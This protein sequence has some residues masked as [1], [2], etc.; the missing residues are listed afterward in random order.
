MKFILFLFMFSFFLGLP[1]WAGQWSFATSQSNTVKTHFKHSIP[2]YSNKTVN[3]K[4]KT[5]SS[6]PTITPSA[7]PSPTPVTDALSNV[8]VVRMTYTPTLPNDMFNGVLT[9][10]TH[11]FTMEPVT[12]DLTQPSHVAALKVRM[13]TELTAREAQAAANPAPTT[14]PSPNAMDISVKNILTNIN[15]TNK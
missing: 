14:S 6:T 4:G 3:S 8:V 13:N 5:P 9:G 2:K 10:L 15:G 12:I 11:P 1:A 7:T